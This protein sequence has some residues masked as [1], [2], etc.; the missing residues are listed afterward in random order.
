MIV[1]AKLTIK[2]SV[3]LFDNDDYFKSIQCTC[4]DK[5]GIIG[6]ALMSNKGVTGRGGAA[7]GNRRPLNLQ[8]NEYPACLYGSFK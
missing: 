4:N 5:G 1:D 6:V 2:K 8:R 7:Q 3:V